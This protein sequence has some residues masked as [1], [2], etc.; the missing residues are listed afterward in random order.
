MLLNV[1]KAKIHRAKVT[2]ANLHYEGSITIDSDLLK[3]SGILPHEQVHVVDIN[4]GQRFV[5]YVI[6]GKSGCGAICL[7]GA[8]ARLVN[9]G[10]LV[11]VIAYGQLEQTE[12]RNH[13]PR[14]VLV[15]EM[16]KVRESYHLSNDVEI[17]PGAS[18][19]RES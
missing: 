14:V 9:V 2:E 7:N 3:A 5:T 4:N 11:I 18:L 1:L 13:K 10:D 6:A 15:D 19:A 12:A 16:N 8:A 17:P